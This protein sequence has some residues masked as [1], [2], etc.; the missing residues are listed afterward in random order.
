VY[1]W[2]TVDMLVLLVMQRNR[3]SGR[4]LVLQ[5]KDEKGGNDPKSC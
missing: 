4:A 1:D 5:H 2:L 3:I